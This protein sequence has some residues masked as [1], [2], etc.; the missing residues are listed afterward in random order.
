MLRSL[1]FTHLNSDHNRH[2]NPDHRPLN[3]PITPT[4]L[5]NESLYDPYLTTVPINDSTH[6]YYPFIH[7]KH[8]YNTYRFIQRI[9]VRSISYAT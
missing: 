6:S 5:F 9:I 1:C 8:P 3:T 4:D 2:T 7:S